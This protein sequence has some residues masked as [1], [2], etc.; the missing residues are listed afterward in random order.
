MIVKQVCAF[1]ENKTGRLSEIAD[2]LASNGIDISALSLADSAD[3]GILRML[4]NDPQKAVQILKDA[5]VVAK[6]TDALAVTIND[7]PGGFA[8][9]VRLLSKKNFEV[10]YMYASVGHLHGKALM[11]LGLDNPA[12]AEAII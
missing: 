7:A 2:I 5:G 12:E 10:K 6:I 9:V 11:I 3:Y 8:E 4:V 1:I